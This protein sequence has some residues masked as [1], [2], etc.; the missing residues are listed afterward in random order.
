MTQKNFRPSRVTLIDGVKTIYYKRRKKIITD[1]IIKGKRGQIQ[2]RIS[3]KKKGRIPITVFGYSYIYTLSN[4]NEYKTAKH[5]AV[6]SAWKQ[7]PFS[8]DDFEII[9]EK[10]IY[11]A[12]I[13]ITKEG[14]PEMTQVIET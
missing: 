14:Y 6:K 8:P 11:V 10:F 7:C 5:V 1:E 13:D 3:F 9:G 2:L 12:T 4:S